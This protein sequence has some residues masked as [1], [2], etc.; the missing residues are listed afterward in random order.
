MLEDEEYSTD[1]QGDVF[2]EDAT[3]HAAFQKSFTIG[4]DIYERLFDGYFEGELFDR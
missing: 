1:E 4:P 3:V 2:A